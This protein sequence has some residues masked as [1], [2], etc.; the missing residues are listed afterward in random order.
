MFSHIA[1]A[2]HTTFVDGVGGFYQFASESASNQIATDTATEPQ[3]NGAG[4]VNARNSGF[5]MV[6]AFIGLL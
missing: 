5:M 3:K 6:L 4:K 2:S 1:I